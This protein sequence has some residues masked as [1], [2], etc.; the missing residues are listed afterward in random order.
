M[1]VSFADLKKTIS[2]AQTILDGQLLEAVKSE[3]PLEEEVYVQ[4][5]NLSKRAMDQADQIRVVVER[6][7]KGE[8]LA[9]KRAR[10]ASYTMDFAP[11]VCVCVCV[12]T[13]VGAW[14]CVFFVAMRVHGARAS[15]RKK[16]LTTS[17]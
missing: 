6:G 5:C 3:A 16:K 7:F 10:Q 2:D 14:V 4:L 11:S 17:L 12:C 9:K 15:K 1:S 13:Y 8:A